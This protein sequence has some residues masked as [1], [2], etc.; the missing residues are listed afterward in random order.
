MVSTDADGNGVFDRVV[1]D[2]TVIAADQERTQTVATHSASGALLSNTVTVRA[3]DGLT[4][5]KSVDGDGDGLFEQVTTVAKAADGQTV[6]TSQSYSA[7]GTLLSKSVSTTSVDGLSTIVRNDRYGLGTDDQILTEVT[8]KNADGSA[9]QTVEQ[10]SG[11][12]SLLQRTVVTESANGLVTRTQADSDGDGLHDRDLL[13]STV[14][15][16]DG[17]QTRTIETRSGNGSLLTG[18]TVV[19]SHDRLLVTRTVDVDGDGQAN[20]RQ[21]SQTTSDGAKTTTEEI[22]N[23]LGQVISR[24]QTTTSANGLVQATTQDV[25]G[26]GIVDGQASAATVLGMDG[27]KTTT[28]RTMAGDG[29]LL[30][31]DVTSQNGNGSLVIASSDLNG[32]GVVDLSTRSET[33]LN[34]D[35]STTVTVTQKSGS[36]V[37]SVKTSTQSANGLSSLVASDLD[38]DG[39]IDQT[40]QNTKQ[41][42][43]NGGVVETQQVRAQDLT[44]V[45]GQIVETSANGRLVTTTLDRNGDGNVD[46]TRLREVL[47]DG[48]VRTT[49]TGRNAAGAVTSTATETVSRNGLET[50]LSID[51][52]GDGTVDRTKSARTEILADGSQRVTRTEYSGTSTLVERSVTTTSGNGLRSNTVWSDATGATTRSHE[53]LTVLAQDG[54]KVTTETF[55]KADGSLESTQTLSQA[56]NGNST[57]LTRDINGDG[58]LDDRITESSLDNGTTTTLHQNLKADGTVSAAKLVTTSADELTVTTLYDG[59]GDGTYETR[60]VSKSEPLADGSSRTTVTQESLVSGAW[61]LKG[62]TV[63]T[64]SGDGLTTSKQWDDTGA[65]TF[66]LSRTSQIVL[67]AD[68]SRV[69]TDRMLTNGVTTR[70]DEHKVSADG[71]TITERADLNGDGTFDQTLTDVTVLNVDGSKTRS[72]TAT[73]ADGSTISSRVTTVS[74]DGLSASVAETSNVTGWA[75]RTTSIVTSLLADGSSRTVKS[76]KNASGQLIE[77]E[78]V[79]KT[80]DGRTKAI[81]RD[82]NGDGVVDHRE[83]ETRF[84]DGRVSLVETRYGSTGNVVSSVS[85]MTSANGQR[86]VIDTDKNGDGVI[87]LKKTID[88]Q[89]FANG[90]TKVVTTVVNAATNAVKSKTEETVSADGT[91]RLESTDVNG[92]GTADQT[93]REELLPSGIRKTT[94]TN[95]AAAKA[96]S[97]IRVGEIYWSDTIPT[98]IETTVSADGLTRNIRMDIDGNGVFEVTATAVTQIDGSTVTTITET[99]ANGTVKAK[100]TLTQSPDGRVTVLSADTQ[101]DGVIDSII[102]TTSLVDG[103]VEKVAVKKTSAGMVTETRTSRIDAIGDLLSSETFDGSNRKIETYVRSADLTATRTRF[104]ASNGLIS[105]LEIFSVDGK[106]KSATL[107]DALSAQAWTRI[108]QSFNAAEQKS[109]ETQFM[110]DG[111]KWITSY[112]LANAYG[113]SRYVQNFNAGGAQVGIYEYRDN[114]TSVSY[115]YDP[116]NAQAWSRVEQSFNASGQKLTETLFMDDGTRWITTYDQANAYG[117]SQYVQNFNAA[118]SQTGV[119]EYGDDGTLLRHLF[120]P[121]N[122]Q[123]WS[124]IVTR[125]DGAN[126]A[127]Y[128]IVNYDNGRWVEATFDVNNTASWQNVVRTYDSSSRLLEESILHDNNT[129]DVSYFDTDNSQGYSKGTKFYEYNGVLAREVS[130]ENN[131]VNY[132]RHWYDALN[133]QSWVKKTM[134]YQALSLVRTEIWYDDGKYTRKT[135]DPNRRPVVVDLDGDGQVSITENTSVGGVRFDWD[136]D[137][138]AD[139]TAWVGAGDGL[140]VIDLAADGSGG[141][142]GNIDQAQ[143]I[144]FSMWPGDADENHVSDLEGLRIAFD[145][146]GDNILDSQDAR[147]SEFR[148]WQDLNQNGVSDAGELRTMSESGIKLLNLLPSTEGAVTF[149]DGSAITG[150]STYETMDGLRHLVADAAFAFTPSRSI[151]SP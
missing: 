141:A 59:N 61:Q 49:T 107:H 92:D 142:D 18:E 146:N 44:L 29:T 12:N 103:A 78:T 16:S 96:S 32:D 129:R 114:G 35:G 115:L 31:E 88:R 135:E 2:V 4:G 40:V 112:D 77:S 70:I 149:A 14:V 151:G 75:A 111:T 140:L 43:G 72:E 97:E 30:R 113:W 109:S 42:L 101:N 38:G 39:D 47:A 102:T 122:A 131:P 7:D 27:G 144:A 28:K 50:V 73:K 130:Y 137:G 23:D 24:K 90:S 82:R 94:V 132:Y 19:T 65:G 85:S 148:I 121:A 10:R 126:R 99:N 41:L 80:A 33:T 37:A 106:L 83:V 119:Y 123:T 15:G 117:W 138:S 46:E 87:D 11:S 68:G 60:V 54:S 98:K 58:K 84:A 145:T 22:L 13:D 71:L 124:R 25:D 143:E 69:T 63:T 127:F 128:E 51:S 53:R 55:R 95:N 62:K 86:T 100:G 6:Q 9:Q 17:S 1:S 147:W 8:V 3:V 66:G 110:D 5:S 76:V 118:G 57:I 48:S 36:S 136:G 67:E 21:V 150:T 89:T 105:S 125:Y 120:D 79:D 81:L 93:V 133:N 116:T 52:N 64:T 20:V 74:K 34:A 139:T 56:G 45:S 108:E 134:Y 104:E 26:N 91:L